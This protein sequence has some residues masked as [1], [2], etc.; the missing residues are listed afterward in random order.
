[1]TP[2]LQLT[3]VIAVMFFATLTRSTFGFGEALV[4]VPLLAL[5]LKVET[6]SALVAISSI[7]NSL[8]IMG[9]SRNST[10]WRGSSWLILASLAGI[11]VGVYVLTHVPEVIVK[12]LLAGV[13][14]SFALFNLSQRHR[15][16]L[17]SDLW[18]FPFGFVGG[19]LGGAY[20]TSGPALVI[21]GTLRGWTPHQFRSIL[22]GVFL[23]NSAV[24]LFM[25]Y[26]AGLWSADV[27]QYLI[28]VLP[29]LALTV[30]L[31]Y[32]LNRRIHPEHF[33]HVLHV[34]LL[35]LGLM[36]AWSTFRG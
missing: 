3:C 27:L 23:T 15:L 13:V 14:I 2:E 35:A 30:P 17:Q 7:A 8:A 34:M 29:L 11:P 22:Q 16:R 28:W 36:L 19:I 20:N 5:V 4:A 31:G 21:F 26:L 6:A 10:D 24:V 12:R 18:A 33:R 1:M 25:H 32:W 9:T